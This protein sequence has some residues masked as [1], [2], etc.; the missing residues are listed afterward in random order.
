MIAM[1]QLNDSW[2]TFSKEALSFLT[3]FIPY[4]VFVKNQ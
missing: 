1:I 2:R 3:V 4:T